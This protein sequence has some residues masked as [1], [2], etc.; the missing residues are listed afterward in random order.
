MQGLHRKYLSVSSSLPRRRWSRVGALTSC[1]SFS[2]TLLPN[3]L[4]IQGVSRPHSHS[5]LLAVVVVTAGAEQGHH[6]GAHDHPHGHDSVHHL[7][8]RAFHQPRHTGA[9][10]ITAVLSSWMFSR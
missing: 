1:T 5:L 7:Q 4:R 10:H 8:C 3:K 2:Q 9:A 6:E